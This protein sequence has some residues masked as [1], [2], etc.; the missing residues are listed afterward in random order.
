ME[1]GLV[2]IIMAVTA[3]ITKA[4]T[5]VEAAVVA[6]EEM[7]MTTMVTETVV[8]GE[9]AVGTTITWATTTPRP[10]TLAQ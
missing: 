8:V 2:D 9:A 1:V 6:M 3:V 4:T 10:L 7:D 5:R